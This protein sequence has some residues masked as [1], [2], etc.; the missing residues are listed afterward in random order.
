MFWYLIWMYQVADNT[1]LLNLKQLLLHKNFVTKNS[2]VSYYL[3]GNNRWWKYPYKNMQT[4]SDAK[5][6]LRSNQGTSETELSF[7]LPSTLTGPKEGFGSLVET[8]TWETEE[9][10]CLLQVSAIW[11]KYVLGIFLLG[12]LTKTN[13]EAKRD[14]LQSFL[15]QH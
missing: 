3:R 15:K 1:L 6:I 2:H 7:V 9:D 5:Y 11:L 13:M 14:L 4:L 10:S 12:L 8:S